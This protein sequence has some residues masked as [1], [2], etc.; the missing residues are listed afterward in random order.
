MPDNAE[1]WQEEV[2]HHKVW[3]RQSPSPIVLNSQTNFFKKSHQILKVITCKNRKFRNLTESNI[4]LSVWFWRGLQ[5]DCWHLN[6]LPL[7]ANCP[8]RYTLNHLTDLT[9]IVFKLP[10]WGSIDCLAC[11]R[12]CK[13]HGSPLPKVQSETWWLWHSGLSL[14]LISVLH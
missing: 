8:L 12:P 14:L 4:S 5:T 11:Y 3:W 7:E 13:E 10:C 1:Q 9:I 6:L 2:N